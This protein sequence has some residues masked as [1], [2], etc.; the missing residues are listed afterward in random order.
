[1]R[2]HF[3]RGSEESVFS[4]YVEGF[5]NII[6]YHGYSWSH[7]IYHRAVCVAMKIATHLHKCCV[8]VRNALWRPIA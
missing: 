3:G 8:Y 5:K 1:M 7:F 6:I 2:S 4:E